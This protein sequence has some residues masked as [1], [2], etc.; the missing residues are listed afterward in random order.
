MEK[1]TIL[2]IDDVKLNL[3]TARDV[4]QE[5]YILYEAS[6]AREGFEILDQVI[7]EI[8]RAHD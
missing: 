3:A 2:M 6:S 7:P 4:L 8:G 1:K 5:D